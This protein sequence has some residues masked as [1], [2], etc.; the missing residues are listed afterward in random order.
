MVT[1]KLND[2]KRV[3]V[4]G[5]LHRPPAC[6]ANL[7]GMTAKNRQDRQNGATFMVIPTLR[8]SKEIGLPGKDLGA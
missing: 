7:D 5:K 3:S 1:S 8:G 6:T 4:P 2:K